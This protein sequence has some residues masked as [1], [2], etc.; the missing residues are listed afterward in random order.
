MPFTDP[1]P[2]VV[3]QTEMAIVLTILRTD[4][5]LLEHLLPR[6]PHLSDL[7][8]EFRAAITRLEAGDG[9][10]PGT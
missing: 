4:L 8:E 9:T 6:H 5:A 1:Q 2:G 3:S 10:A 7:A